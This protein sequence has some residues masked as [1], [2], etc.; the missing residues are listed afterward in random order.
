MGKFKELREIE[1]EA[2]KK[3]IWFTSDPHYGHKN[4]IKYCLRPFENNWEMEK[5]LVANY[6]ALVKP[7]DIVYFI[8][9]VFFC[10]IV[11]SKAI[12][13]KLN[14]YKILIRGNHDQKASKMLEIGFDE[15]HEKLELEINGQKVKL[16]HFPF[17][18]NTEDIDPKVIARIR[19]IKAE[20]R[21]TGKDR[22][23]TLDAAL[24]EYPYSNLITEEQKDR[25]IKYDMRFWDLRYED[26]GGYLLCGHVHEKWTQIGKM[27]NVGV[28]V[29]NF[30]PMS[31]AEI[32]ELIK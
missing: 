10:G 5:A 24:N 11:Q 6:N 29:R 7:F 28:D 8:G 18:P 31:L 13:K 19:Q 16:S 26:D 2:V 20:Q 32:E 3:D 23:S 25:L 4:V 12:L 27:I 21:K 30:K 15:V 9:D 17:R 14:G 22:S 1:D